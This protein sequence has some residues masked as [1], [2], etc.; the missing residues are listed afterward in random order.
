MVIDRKRTNHHNPSPLHFR[1]A[2]AKF[3]STD[4]DRQ[5]V[6]AMM[7]ARKFISLM[8]QI[9]AENN[10]PFWRAVS[11]WNSNKPLT[12]AEIKAYKTSR[13]NGYDD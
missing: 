5:C 4:H 3:A 7:N 8:T 11:R 2:I 1:R 12:V 10:R 9:A 6:A 13:E